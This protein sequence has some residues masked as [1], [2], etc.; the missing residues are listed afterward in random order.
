MLLERLLREYL[1][2]DLMQMLAMKEEGNA[3]ILKNGAIS[4]DIMAKISSI[5]I[6]IF[7]N[8]EKDR[9]LVMTP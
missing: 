5:D 4:S 9:R 7:E 8:K 1:K 6:V 3:F 2:I